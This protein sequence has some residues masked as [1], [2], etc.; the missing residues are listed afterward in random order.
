MYRV[1]QNPQRH[2]QAARS[3]RKPHSGSIIHGYIS[4]KVHRLL[5]TPRCHWQGPFSLN[6]TFAVPLLGSSA[7]EECSFL[8]KRTKKLLAF[9]VGVDFVTLIAAGRRVVVSSCASEVPA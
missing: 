6:P 1:P 4:S 8:K 5:T 3:F 2:P 7:K 9:R